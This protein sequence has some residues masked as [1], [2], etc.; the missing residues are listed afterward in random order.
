MN[1]N[2][3][4]QAITMASGAPVDPDHRTTDPVTGLQKGYV[5]LSQ[6]ERAKGFIRPVRS[7]YTH[8]GKTPPQNLQ[9]LT[10]D[11]A[12]RYESCGYVKYEAYPES[13]SPRVGRYWTQAELDA[14]TKGG[15][16]VTTTMGTAIAE[17]YARDPKF[18]QHT[19]CAGCRSHFPVSEFRWVGSQ[20]LV[21]S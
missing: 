15:C 4:S 19:Y 16:G 18:Y 20:E 1:P 9:D 13:E 14:A 10:A 6:E 11:E 7:S 12:K 8:I 5:V 3:P 17:T 2:N 21:G